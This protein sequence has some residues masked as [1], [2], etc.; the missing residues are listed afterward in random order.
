MSRTLELPE[1]KLVAGNAEVFDDVGNDAARD[2]ARMPQERDNSI[3]T[4][5]IGI[6]P[7]ASGAAQ[8]DAA[9]LFETPFQL[10][11]I[12]RGIFSHRSGRNNEFVAEGGRDRAASFEQSF[13]MSLG[14]VL[15]MEDCLPA[16]ASVGVTTG[17]QSGFGDPHAVFVSPRLN[18]RNGD[19]HTEG[20]L[21]AFADA[22]NGCQQN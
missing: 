19:D 15:K 22:V 4:K 17:K 5:G 6:M 21:T 8:M 16:I 20:T 11:A 7:V 10:T 9:N 1:I 14:G 18:F 3:G 12:N 13:Q 2:V